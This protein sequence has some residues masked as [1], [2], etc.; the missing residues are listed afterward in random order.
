[1]RRILLNRARSKRCIKRGG[2]LQRV[3]LDDISVAAEVPG[4]DLLSIDE[5]LESLAA[6]NRECADLVK[7]RFFTGLSVAEAAAAMGISPRTAKRHMAYARAWLYE[8]LR[9]DGTPSES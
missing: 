5:A 2:Q 3:P 1:M 6:E 9:P 7:M 8:A 4:E